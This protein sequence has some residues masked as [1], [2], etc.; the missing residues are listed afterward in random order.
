M[1]T[2]LLARGLDNMERRAQRWMGTRVGAL[3]SL[4]LSLIW[5]VAFVG[6]SKGTWSPLVPLAA[7]AVLLAVFWVAIGRRIWRSMG[8]KPER[9]ERDS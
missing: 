6:A 1:A 5:A 2:T 9:S 7:M 8:W 3:V 4:A